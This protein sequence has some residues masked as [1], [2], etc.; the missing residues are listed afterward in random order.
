MNVRSLV[1]LAVALVGVPM[2][3]VIGGADLAGVVLAAPEAQQTEVRVIKRYGAAIRDDATADAE[4]L[5]N[6]KCNETF[7]LLAANGSWRQIFQV[8]G[9]KDELTE[10]EDDDIFKNLNLIVLILRVY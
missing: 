8:V 3:P 1:A 5:I 6:A 4:V 2:M 10:D 9:Q 7:M